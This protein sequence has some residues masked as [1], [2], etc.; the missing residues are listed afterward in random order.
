MVYVLICIFFGFWKKKKINIA[1]KRENHTNDRMFK[2]D[3]YV[4]VVNKV[5]LAKNI[6]RF[7]KIRF[8]IMTFLWNRRKKCAIRKIILYSYLYID[9]DTLSK[10]ITTIIWN[11]K[12]KQNS[13]FS[14]AL[15]SFRIYTL[16]VPLQD[17][18]H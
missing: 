5:M 7:V 9:I 10:N 17:I 6:S 15:F 13:A 8:G 2:H 14:L 12:T 4:F 3:P 16:S 11:D 1:N 18:M